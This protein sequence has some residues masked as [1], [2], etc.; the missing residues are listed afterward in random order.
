MVRVD[1]GI[2]AAARADAE[3]GTTRLTLDIAEGVALEAI[4]DHTAP[5]LTGY[6]LSGRIASG[7]AITWVVHDER[8][9][10]TIWT[11]VANYDVLPQTGGI[12]A[13]RKVDHST[14]RPF[15]EPLAVDVDHRRPPLAEAS[16]D[17]GSRADVLVLWTP[18]ARDAAGGQSSI[19][20]AIDLY[21][22]TTNDALRNSGTNLQIR[23][24]AAE[25]VAYTEVK[26]SSRTD[27][28]RLRGTTDGHMDAIHARRD[29]LRADLV[30]L[31][32]DNTGVAGIAYTMNHLSDGF[33]PFAFSVVAYTTSPTFAAMT[34]AHELGH[35]MGLAHDRFV[36]SA[37]SAHAF[38]RGYVNAQAF[39]AGAAADAC[40]TTL[41]AYR[42]RCYR[43]GFAVATRVPYFST[44]RRRYP[45]DGG[46][47]LGVPKT[48]DVDGY[49]GPADA[50]L[51]IEQVRRTVANFRFETQADDGDTTAT[52]T[53]VPAASSTLF[54]ALDENDAD[55]FR[56]QLTQASSLRV[57][58]EGGVDTAGALLSAEGV[59]LAEDDDGGY[60]HNF[61]IERTL[62]AGTYFIK[63]TGNNS[64]VGSYGLVV[65]RRPITATD[66]HGDTA[67]SSTIVAIPSTTAATLADARDV[68]TFRFE[69]SERRLVEATTSGALDTVGAL[70]IDGD[71]L[72]DA[73][74]GDETFVDDDSGPAG[75]FKIVGK[76]DAGVYRLAVRGW[77]GAHG[78]TTLRV[79][80]GIGADD[81]GDSPAAA[82]ALTLPARVAGAIEVL[83]DLDVF[84][85]EV[86]KRGLL[87]L[88]TEGGTDTFG[89]LTAADGSTIASNDDAPDNWPNFAIGAHVEPG[90]Y[91][92]RLR[93]WHTT[94]GPYLLT[95]SLNTAPVAARALPDLSLAPAA[96]RGVDVSG[97]FRDPEGAALDYAARSSAEA[98]ARATASGATVTVIA[99][100]AGSATVTVT[101]TDPGGLSAT[102]SFTVTVQTPNQPP[103]VGRELADLTLAPA[104]TADVA[105]GGAFRD[106]EG[107]DLVYAVRSSVEAVASVTASG[108][109]A[110]VTARSAGEA[111]V[112]VTATDPGGLS[113]TQSFAVTVRTPNQPPS[114]GR[115]LAD[116]TLAPAATADV[117]LGG[118]FR[119]PEGADLVYAVRSSVEAVASVTASGATATVTAR[120][121]GEATVTVTATDP[122]GLAASQ[123]F[124]VT[125]AAPPT[126]RRIAPLQLAANGES[127][128][129]NL[130][131]TF[132][133]SPGGAPLTFSATSTAPALASVTVLDSLL[134]VMANG[135]GAAGNL[136]AR[137]TATDIRG[138]SA[139][140]AIHVEVSP[141][142]RLLRRWL[143][144]LLKEQ[145]GGPPG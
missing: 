77:D 65:L 3:R 17:D 76:L 8:V 134:T 123:S 48:S 79:S 98:V 130:A 23:L 85:I 119:D 116:L 118:A 59:T 15:G 127:A 55:H 94:T 97:A 43:N 131:E 16:G 99:G 14:A 50:A 34:F 113:A 122:D 143:I 20:T 78:T 100:S 41:M 21:V 61:L 124:V 105:L 104:A 141:T 121:A 92:L 7:G 72:K 139:T 24:V 88:A 42:N 93:G 51:A 29:T 81:H 74:G 73:V 80:F 63:V 54:A 36:T 30:S 68:D 44:P 140:L 144:E 91:F 27:L 52:A 95:A 26:G 128:D 106:P 83:F 64:A 125:V 89:T 71:L 103:L 35:N 33:A 84:R 60:R 57:A 109:T 10:G 32:T 2:L 145:R 112:T 5:T 126:I 70:R 45:A 9:T 49:D 142:Q 138:L 115:G 13:I 18:A 11:P 22:A 82:T 90:I 47:A 107:A 1:N 19:R 133:A 102:Q 75:N 25:E 117:A 67:A 120:S 96:T 114:V 56:I 28:V 132:E 66:D 86:A 4:V 69:L 53:A 46:D 6:S 58:S 87:R 39:V 136:E 40:W 110:T 137:V 38:A 12:H 31:I 135:D 108:A 111:T 37:N 62:A 129:V 101:A